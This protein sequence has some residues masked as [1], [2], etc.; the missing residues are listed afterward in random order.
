MPTLSEQLQVTMDMQQHWNSS[1][2]PEMQTRGH[3]VRTVIPRQVRGVLTQ[4]GVAG[5]LVEGSDGAGRKSRIPWV[6]VF[7]PALSPAA[8]QGWYLVYLFA[9]DGSGVYLSLN[10]GTTTPSQGAFAVREDDY[11]SEKV[12]RAKDVFSQA[13]T[14][15]S[16]LLDSIKLRANAE[17]GDAY[18]RGNVF[19]TYYASNAV[20][21]DAQLFA[22]LTRLVGLLGVLYEAERNAIPSQRVSYL[23]TWNPSL[24]PWTDLKETVREVSGL[25]SHGRQVSWSTL[26][27]QV[28]P[29]DRLFLVRLHD[30]PKGIIG[31]G[32]ALSTPYQ[33]PHWDGTP[34]KNAQYIDLRWDS[35]L[36][37]EASPPLGLSALQDID[38]GYKW[39]PQASGLSI[40]EG[41]AAKLEAAWNAH[42]ALHRPTAGSGET[43]PGKKPTVDRPAPYGEAQLAAEVFFD[44]ETAHDMCDLLRTR[45]NVVIQGPPGV[46]KTFVARRLAY[47]LMGAKDD[48]RI[49]WVQFHQ[50]YSYEEFI[51]GYRPTSTGGFALRQGI[52][53]KFCEL[54]RSRSPESHV[55]VIDEINRGNLSRIFGEALSLLEDDKRGALSARL[56]YSPDGQRFTIPNNVFVIGLMN[57]ADR[58]LAVVDYAIRRRFRFVDLEPQFSSPR[59]GEALTAKG[60]SSA[61]IARIRKRLEA[62]NDSIRDDSRNLGRGFEIGHSYFCPSGPITEEA[63]WYKRVVTFEIA[64]LL[65]E[66]WFDAPEKADSAVAGLLNADSDS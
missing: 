12:E 52:F 55:F 64:P 6:R 40:P 57:T 37:P 63:L 43:P 1:N 34:G 61:M 66:Y 2:T 11:L 23:L 27:G 18:E 38:A 17:L 3:T 48:S 28:R 46:G 26:S 39:T 30:E 15:T 33:R 56:A 8:T 65:R 60:V 29:G 20:P 58:S 62:L 14:D 45:M 24:F 10:Q 42:W 54:A 19:S 32:V 36:D 47:A 41:T 49:E 50:S 31:S 44:S 59:F 7:D 5:L 53:T 13:G 4:L 35:L 16:G 21:D 9:F 25:D 51:E 22:D